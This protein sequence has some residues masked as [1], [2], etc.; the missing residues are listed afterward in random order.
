[1]GTQKAGSFP[2]HY[3][4]EAETY[5]FYRIPKI[6]FTDAQFRAMSTDAKL[7]YSL[8]LDRMQL[9]LQNR[10]LDEKQRVFIYY[11]VE[12]IQGALGCGH[13]KCSK[14]LAELDKSGLITRIRQGLGKPDRIY[15]H[16]C[17]TASFPQSFPQGETDIQETDLQTSENR[18]SGELEYGSAVIRNLDTNKT[19][20][21][22]TENSENES[23]Y[24]GEMERK[25]WER[26]QYRDLIKRQVE[27]DIL[28]QEKD[29]DMAAEL[30]EL[31]IDTVCSDQSYIWICGDQKP[32][33]VVK[34]QFLKL[35]HEHIQYVIGCI[36]E[37]TT[38][39]KNIKQYMLATLYNAPL[40][41]NHYYTALVNHDMYGTD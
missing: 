1:M 13:S 21:N 19:E 35:T 27:Y 28:M 10:W 36:R 18:I 9:S 31:I 5:T 24:S 34:S 25:E 39:V 11:S 20:K 6:L 29:A 22:K 32:T 7:L 17:V 38:H 41:I 15:V 37:N 14:L 16:K 3:G 33:A 12:A 30:V 4:G 26:A 2:Y 8:M 40:T 23:I